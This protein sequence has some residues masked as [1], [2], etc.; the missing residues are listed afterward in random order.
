MGDTSN[1]GS[2]GFTE[3]DSAVDDVGSVPSHARE[4]SGT[5]YGSG[6]RVSTS[7]GHRNVGYDPETGTAT[8]DSVTG[9]PLPAAQQMGRGG[10]VSG[11]ADKQVFR[12]D[13][14]PDGAQLG[15]QGG[16]PDVTTQ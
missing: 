4:Q 5:G 7:M 8:L 9:Q 16:N 6:G 1:S 14:N 2:G 15:G 13:S 11:A 12:S 3:Q 10:P